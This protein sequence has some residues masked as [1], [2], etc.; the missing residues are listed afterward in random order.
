MKVYKNFDEIRGKG[1]KHR[2]NITKIFKNGIAEISKKL[3]F[4][5]KLSVNFGTLYNFKKF[6]INQVKICTNFI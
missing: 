4:L 3:P 6:W 5:R 2:D 1:K